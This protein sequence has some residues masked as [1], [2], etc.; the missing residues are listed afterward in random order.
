[1]RLRPREPRFEVVLL[2]RCVVE[3]AAHNVDDAVRDAERLVELRG[4]GGGGGVRWEVEVVVRAAVAAAVAARHLL[5]VLDHLLLHLPRNVALGARQRELLDLLELVDAEDPQLVA[6]VRPRL[7]PE[8][9]RVAGVA[10]RQLLRRQP[11][12]GVVRADRLLRSGDQVLVL[13]GARHLRGAMRWRGRRRIA[14]RIARRK[15]AP[16]RNCA[17]RHL[18]QRLVIIGELRDLPHQRLVHREGR[19]QHRRAALRQK[20]CAYEMSAWLSSAPAPTRK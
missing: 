17:P 7:L 2:R 18:V 4:G 19:L 15:I 3:R 5:R 11:L 6:A 1:M 16:A 13:A 10:D 9:R 14:D 12:A 8:A 20:C